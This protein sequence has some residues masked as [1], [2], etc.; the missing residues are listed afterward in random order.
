MRISNGEEGMDLPGEYPL[1]SELLSPKYPT[2]PLPNYS[3]PR[4]LETV[5]ATNRRHPTHRECGWR[6]AVRYSSRL[7]SL[8]SLL[9]DA[10]AP[11]L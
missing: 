5:V 3:C 6:G 7:Q 9:E 4:K 1:L 11:G 2:F 8:S 10:L